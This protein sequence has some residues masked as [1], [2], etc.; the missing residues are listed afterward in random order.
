MLPLSKNHKRYFI[1]SKDDGTDFFSLTLLSN[2]YIRSKK[3]IDDEDGCL[4]GCCAV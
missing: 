2:T 4:L 1:I 3:K